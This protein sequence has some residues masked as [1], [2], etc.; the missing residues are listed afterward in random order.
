MTAKR[1][2]LLSSFISWS[3]EYKMLQEYFQ[4]K[5]DIEETAKRFELVLPRR[6][7]VAILQSVGEKN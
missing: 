1:I 5:D 7:E 3:S 6:T 2:L 4:R